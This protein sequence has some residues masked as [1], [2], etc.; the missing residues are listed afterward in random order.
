MRSLE[1]SSLSPEQKRACDIFSQNYFAFESASIISAGGLSLANVCISGAHFFV[2][3]VVNRKVLPHESHWM[4]NQSKSRVHK[5]V[6]D[7]CN[8]KFAKLNP[9]R[10]KSRDCVETNKGLPSYKLWIFEVESNLHY[11]P[12]YFLWC[13]KGKPSPNSLPPLVKEVTFKRNRD[14]E[15]IHID[16][17]AFLAD[18][19]DKE[20]AIQLGWLKKP[21]YVF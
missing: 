19:I 4:W 20:V 15:E 14:N 7:R 1:Y 17:L 10:I 11:G 12:L 18:F 3:G 5:K 13:E 9:R 8:I 2:D 16:Q 21:K 6:T